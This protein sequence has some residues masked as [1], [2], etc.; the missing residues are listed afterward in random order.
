MT[1]SWLLYYLFM[2]CSQWDHVLFVRIL[3]LL[4]MF[5]Y[6]KF[7]HYFIMAYSHTNCS[8]FVHDF[9]TCLHLWNLTT[10]LLHIF[11]YLKF[12][13]CFIIHH[14]LFTYKLFPTCSWLLHM[15]TYLKFDHRISMFV[16]ILRLLHMLTYLKF[17]HYFI[18]SCSQIVLDLF[19]TCAQVVHDLFTNLS[20]FVHNFSGLVQD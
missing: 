5:P 9:F 4:H 19:T 15:F 7:E 1:C 17:D 6:L 3:R 12:E 20:Q 10:R 16:R 18:M 14:G 2:T 11:P 13:H 8:K